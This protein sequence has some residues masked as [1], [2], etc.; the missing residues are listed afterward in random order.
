ME[1][2]DCKLGDRLGLAAKASE[3]LD[4]PGGRGLLR[5]EG[6]TIRRFSTSGAAVILLACDT[7]DVVD[8]RREFELSLKDKPWRGFGMG[9]F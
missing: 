8:G 4:G 1:G 5:S 2:G 6:E 3:L 9:D 7:L